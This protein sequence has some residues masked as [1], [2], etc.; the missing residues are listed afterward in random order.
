MLKIDTPAKPIYTK[1]SNSNINF[2]GKFFFSKPKDTLAL[3]QA[4]KLNS[5]AFQ[6]I[7]EEF[8]KF[9]ENSIKKAYDACLNSDSNIFLPAYNLLKDLRPQNKGLAGKILGRKD[10][11]NVISKFGLDF[12]SNMLEADKNDKYNHTEY[13]IKF[14]ETVLKEFESSTPVKYLNII[15]N[16]KDNEG[17]TNQYAEKLFQ[18]FK[19]KNILHTF[20]DFMKNLS[21]LPKIEQ[22]F[23]GKYYTKIKDNTELFKILELV[24]GKES[25]KLIPQIDKDLADFK[26]DDIKECLS[27]SK[28]KSGEARIFNYQKLL[29]LYKTDKNFINYSSFLKDNNGY[30]NDKNVN[31]VKFMSKII[32]SKNDLG[33]Y[34]NIVKDDNG[35]I[36]DDIAEKLQTVINTISGSKRDK[37]NHNNVIYCIDKLKNNNN[38]IQW[39]YVSIFY[40]LKNKLDN[41]GKRQADKYFSDILNETK[42]TNGNIIPKFVEKLPELLRAEFLEEIPNIFKMS[43]YNN[44]IKTDIYD[45]AVNILKQTASNDRYEMSKFLSGCVDNTGNLDQAKFK[46]LQNIQTKGIKS[47]IIKIAN[48]LQNKD[49]NLSKKG[50]DLIGTLRKNSH[51]QIESDLAAIVST[52]RDKNG[53][54]NDENINAVINLQS[55]KSRLKLSELLKMCQNTENVIDANKYKVIVHVVKNLNSCSKAVIKKIVDYSKDRHGVIDLEVLKLLINLANR[56]QDIDAYRDVIPAYR[57]LYKFENVTSLSQLNLRQKRDLMQAIKRYNYITQSGTFRSILNPKILPNNDSEYCS[58]MARLSHSIGINVPKLSN[59]LKTGFFNA[60][61]NLADPNKDFMNIDFNTNTPVLKLNYSLRDFKTNV[62]N[63]VKTSHYSDRVKALDYFGF[64]LKNNNGVLEMT[65][66]PSA[67]KP[68]GRLSAIKDKDVQNLIKKLTPEVIKFTQSNTVTIKNSP[69]LSK[70]LTA[71]I[72]AF[73]EFLTTIGKVQHGTHDFTLDVHS[74][75]VLQEVMKN[76]L[77]QTLSEKDKRL[78]RIAALFHDLTKAENKPDPDHPKNSAF[79]IY[80]LLDK[81]DM[82]EKNKLKIY[83]VIKNHSWLAHYDFTESTAQRTAFN[84]RSGNS[85]LMQTMLTEADLKGVQKND[86]FYMAYGDKLDKAKTEVNSALLELQKTAINL[87]QTKIPNASE[88]NTHSP[89]VKVINKDGI[90]NTILYLQNNIDLQKA[91]FKNCKSLQ[92]FNIL[93]HG[94]DNKDNASMFQALGLI[95]SNALLST[96]YIIYS[97]QNY[98][99]FRTEGFVLDVPAANIHAAY[100]RD[101]GSGC[102]KTIRDLFNT[103]LFHNKEQRNFISE[104]IKKEFHLNNKNYIKLFD[105]IEDRSMDELD[106]IDPKIAQAYRN[107][108]IKMEIAKRSFGRNYNEIL[109]TSPKI[110]GIFCYDKSPEN[111]SSYLRRYAE[112][113]DIPIIVFN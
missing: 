110:Q 14:L 92:D 69:D 3:S 5:E 29:P 81:L 78:I 87:P 30:I 44:Q 21:S 45:S 7:K 8:K 47:N 89:N 108:F 80:Y 102:K 33:N 51:H 84:M 34:A 49:G 6:F 11:R 9:G 40:S 73:P 85:F 111:V 93:V 13:N 74:L 79:D 63:I 38:E 16:S 103:Y 42:D 94:L 15:V 97:K 76:P 50:L 1:A 96:S 75:K 46:Q 17:N 104:Q 12:V 41:S 90:K 18:Y 20:S 68:D 105:L 88:L 43:K 72:Q 35:V 24:H 55:Y 99:A 37:I 2:Q 65:G 58:M 60:L 113:N 26:I 48:A 36:K 67:D 23:I 66:F 107:L 19:S 31:F 62:W 54:M 112:R 95:D 61:D 82:K 64:E 56:G 32:S 57:K 83:Q 71:I 28:S 86:R 22:E 91:G 39:D 100:W 25:E 27:N 59:E 70:D 53:N 101:F 4:A 98:R 106:Q 52:C 10:E 109:V 77:Y